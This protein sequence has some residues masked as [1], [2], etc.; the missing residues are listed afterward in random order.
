MRPTYLLVISALILGSSGCMS[1]RTKNMTDTC[2]NLLEHNDQSNARRFVRDAERQLEVLNK[3][4]NRF[5]KV[6]RDIQ[7]HDALTFKP[8]LEECLWQLKS[9]QS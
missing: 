1:D 2:Q 9:R 3:P 6:L 8:A 5:T 7:D 4:Q